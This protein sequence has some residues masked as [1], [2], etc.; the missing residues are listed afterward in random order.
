M[1]AS[2][3]NPL[4]PT[5]PNMLLPAF[6]PRKISSYNG[7]PPC[8]AIRKP[9][10][11]KVGVLG[12][13]PNRAGLVPPPPAGALRGRRRPRPALL[14]DDDAAEEAEAEED[15]LRGAAVDL[16]AVDHAAASS[17]PPPAPRPAAPRGPALMTSA[18]VLRKASLST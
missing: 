7:S 8:N 13:A 9:L 16:A 1:T 2:L 11:S 4:G 5:A 18:K 12:T 14:D 10:E 3:R 17:A 15:A 6:S